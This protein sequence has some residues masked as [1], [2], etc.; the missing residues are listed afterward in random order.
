MEFRQFYDTLFNIFERD[1]NGHSL[2]GLSQ[3]EEM[4]ALK[5][6]WQF[7]PE[8]IIGFRA[9]QLGNDAAMYEELPS[10]GFELGKMDTGHILYDTSQTTTTNQ[11]PTRKGGMW[12]FA[13]ADIPIA[14][15]VGKNGLPRKNLAMDYNFFFVQTNG[16]DVIKNLIKQHVAPAVVAAKT[17]QLE[18]QMY[19]SYVNYFFG[20][21]NGNR[22]P[23][24]IGHH[25]SKWN[26]G[27]YWNAMRR[28]A[29]Q[30]C[31][32]PEVRCTTYR[33]LKKFM[34]DPTTRANLAA[35]QA[36]QFEKTNY[37]DYY[38]YGSGRAIPMP[39][40]MNQSDDDY[41]PN[42]RKMNDPAEAHE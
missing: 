21:Y 37:T 36:G 33:D 15:T 17:K 1:Y 22:A 42:N 26:G 16:V 5:M 9:P 28:I 34:D 18:D 2:K 38:K 32:L 27:A 7:G 14:G 4:N 19:Y 10:P 20:N 23:V 29:K 24:N 25:F 13:L 11:W 3:D 8:E 40:L 30:V 41:N 6:H 12:Q 35:Y 39:I 31:G